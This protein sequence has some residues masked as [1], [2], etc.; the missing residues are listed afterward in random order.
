M[1]KVFYSSFIAAAVLLSSCGTHGAEKAE[2]VSAPQSEE[3]SKPDQRK[4]I[5]EY[6]KKNNIKGEFKESGLFVSIEEPGT[7]DKFPTVSN[8]VKAEY[9]G[10]LL[11]GKVFDASEPGSPIEFPLGRVIPGWIEGLQLLKKGGK[12][13]LIIPSALGYGSSGSGPIPPDAVLVFDVKL[14]DWK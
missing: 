12:A 9:T 3:V 8:T 2:K 13:K 5:E 6:V 7:G 14:V 4:V 10:Y 1:K 11:D